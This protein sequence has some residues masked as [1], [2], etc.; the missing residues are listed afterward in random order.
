MDPGDPSTWQERKLRG[1]KMRELNSA[2]MVEVCNHQ[3][4]WDTRQHPLLCDLLVDIRD[5]REYGSMR[6]EVAKLDPLGRRLVVL[7]TWA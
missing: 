5:P 2:G 4:L 3:S 7:D 6:F 1:H